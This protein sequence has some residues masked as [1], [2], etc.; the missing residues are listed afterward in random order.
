AV[1]Q[2]HP[3]VREAVVV[4]RRDSTDDQRLVAY[5]TLSADDSRPEMAYPAQLVAFLQP[6]LPEFMLPSAVVVLP[7]LPR[8]PNGKTDRRA[9]PAPDQ[10]LFGTNRSVDL[11]RTPL[12]EMLIELWKQVLKVEAIGIHDNFFVLG[13]HS[14]LATQL[15]TRLRKTFE[16]EL[17]LK[18]IF[19]AQTVAQLAAIIT[20][21]QAQSVQLATGQPRPQLVAVSRNRPL[22]LSF[23]QERLWFLD[24]LKPDSPLYNIPLVFALPETVHLSELEQAFTEMIRRHEILRT[25]FPSFEGEPVQVIGS[26]VDFHFE[27]HFIPD[28]ETAD[29]RQITAFLRQ[30]FNLERGPLLRGAIFRSATQ[31]TIVAVSVH[32]IVFDGWSSGVLFRELAQIYRALHQRQ[33]PGL[34]ELPIQYADYAVWQR[35]WFQGAVFESELAFWKNQLAG[36]PPLLELPTD[37]PRPV[38]RSFQGARQFFE[39]DESA[40]EKLK[41]LSRQENVTLFMVLL[42]AYVVLLA[43]YSGQNDISVGTPVANRTQAETEALIGFFVNTLVIRTQLEAEPTFLEVLRQIKHTVLDVFAHQEM[44]FEKLVEVLQPERNLSHTPLFQAF[45][46]FQAASPAEFKPF[47]E[48]APVLPRSAQSQPAAE[49]QRVAPGMAK[50]D[51]TLSIFEKGAKL[52]GAFE[53]STDLFDHDTLRRMIGHFQT[54]VSEV[55]IQAD[56]SIRRLPLLTQ[57][58]LDQQLIQ[59]NETTRLYPVNRC[60]QAL[61]MEQVTQTPDAIAVQFGDLGDHLLSPPTL[62]FRQLHDQAEHLAQLLRAAGVGPEVL[63]GLCIERSLEMVVGVLGILKAGGAYV[64]MEPGYPLE[65]LQ[66]MVEDTQMPVVLVLSK[67]ANRFAEM[68]VTTFCL[69]ALPEFIQV[70]PAEEKP[71]TQPATSLAYVLYTSGTTGKPKGVQIEHR[72]IVNY[73]FGVSERVGFEPGM[74]Y[75]M[76]QPLTVDSCKTVLFPPLLFGGCLHVITKE[77][78]LNPEALSQYFDHHRIDVLKIAPSHLAALQI[79]PFTQ[80]LLPRKRLV[81]GGEG[82]TW[83]WVHSFDELSDPACLFFNH[84]GPTETTVGVLTNPIQKGRREHSSPNLPLGKP[85]PNCTM[86]IL[87]QFLQPVP[88]GVV[89]EL[90]IGGDCVARGYL[91]RAELTAERFVSGFRVQGSGFRVS[92]PETFDQSENQKLQNPLNFSNSKIH[93][94]NPEPR[95]LAWYRSGDLAR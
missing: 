5:V 82:S 79:P 91:N 70:E 92:K 58:E 8:L 23:A 27:E 21:A 69:D 22:P 60:L 9:L 77:L 10:S 71:V 53:Y 65:R 37:R 75:A 84:Y 14:L 57:P 74:S 66:F 20:Q 83:D 42:T 51:L 90:F 46:V 16:I 40:T 62:T 6:H 24:Q 50:F 52:S 12:E 76:V 47:G 25:T 32:H 73:V 11:P 68:T 38:V 17:P 31:K 13:G 94:L 89:G 81:V 1:L 36:I 61:F 67:D 80:K 34:P 19:E 45:F 64:P 93:T 95:T 3:L 43:R 2:R 88:V 39:F 63:V 7:E 78:S 33:S 35:N 4:V 85:L 28:S 30:P 55:I 87:D 48:S 18:R 59:W 56:R 29:E 44:P 49:D 41:T 86:F 54:L 26:P 15:I 72:Q